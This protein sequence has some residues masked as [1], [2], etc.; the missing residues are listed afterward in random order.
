MD[1]QLQNLVQRLKSAIASLK[2]IDINELASKLNN[3]KGFDWENYLNNYLI[4]A[5]DSID[6]INTNIM[7]IESQIETAANDLNNNAAL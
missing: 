4:N 5:E 1:E 3:I 2:A 7:A 6:E